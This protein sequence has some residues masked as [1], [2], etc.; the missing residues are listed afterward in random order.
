MADSGEGTHLRVLQ[1][2]V[3]RLQARGG[4]V[5]VAICRSAASAA[6]PRCSVAAAPSPLSPMPSPLLAHPCLQNA[7]A[8]LVQSNQELNTAIEEEGDDED[9]TFKTA[10][11]VRSAAGQPLFGCRAGMEAVSPIACAALL[12]N[13]SACCPCRTT[14]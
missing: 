10:I 7:V 4:D 12:N 5:V 14:L 2:E 13:D 11:E 8:H 9:R 3:D 6:R 1:A